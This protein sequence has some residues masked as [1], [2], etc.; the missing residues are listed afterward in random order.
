MTRLLQDW[1][2]KSWR[3]FLLVKVHMQTTF[4]DTVFHAQVMTSTT[5]L[6]SL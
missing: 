4:F 6:W 1:D 5:I 3:D 2:L